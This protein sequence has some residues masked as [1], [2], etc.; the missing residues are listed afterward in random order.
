M[1]VK[2]FVISLVVLTL[3]FVGLSE[4]QQQTKVPK[5]GWLGARSAS[6]IGAEFFTK[7][8]RV[9]GYVEGK[10]IA[11]EYR[12][13]DDKVDRL[14]GLADELLRLKPDVLITP[15]FTGALA[16]KNATRT[17]PVVFLGVADPV[18]L[19][20]VDSLARPDERSVV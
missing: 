18:A 7:E 3:A 5:V 15:A 8:L 19:G 2:A 12:F 16:L 11:F 1:G 20:L 6:G 17:I 10:N 13:A 14:P 9:L 4:A